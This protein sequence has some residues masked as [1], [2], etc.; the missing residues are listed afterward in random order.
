MPV[1]TC[2]IKNRATDQDL[3]VALR[4]DQEDAILQMLEGAAEDADILAN[5]KQHWHIILDIDTLITFHCKLSL[6]Y[7]TM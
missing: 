4:T 2:R 6:C 5:I 3:A 7:M 1:L